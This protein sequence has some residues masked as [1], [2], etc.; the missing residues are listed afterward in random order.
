MPMSQKHV[1]SL[2][3]EKIGLSIKAVGHERIRR[4]LSRRMDACGIT[5]QS[6]YLGYLSENIQEWEELVESVV[7]PETWFFRNQKSFLFLE[8]YITTEWL[9]RNSEQILRILSI[10]CATGEEAYS[11]AMTLT[12][13]GFPLERLHLD[14]ADIS[15]RSLRKAAQGIYSRESFREK[16]QF[17]QIS[18][19]VRQK[20]RWIKGNLLDP[21]FLID[22]MPYHVI[23]CRNLMIYLSDS[24]R[25]QAMTTLNRLLS[26]EGLLFVG[27][28]ELPLFSLPGMT[29]IIQSGIF[30]FRKQRAGKIRPSENIGKKVCLSPPIMV[31]STQKPDIKII[32]KKEQRLETKEDNLSEQAEKFADQGYLDKAAELYKKHLSM[33]PTDAKAHFM[34]GLMMLAM[35]DETAA[36]LWFNK[37]IYLDPK[38][39]EALQHLA[40][41]RE[42]QG[43]AAG[44]SHLRHRARR[45]EA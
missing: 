24:A 37:T 26:P 43:D 8:R 11:V 18:D 39:R 44:A 36:E 21:E 1:E 29:R 12:D 34:M 13:A 27:H 45:S 7:I 35:K 14:G 32:H 5:D 23:F 33:Y 10:P 6:I 4:A 2:L 15:G 22:E 19:P 3:E 31:T 16:E 42:K 17:R 28:A 9:P 40:L 38:H 41:I 20:I 25:R 30:A